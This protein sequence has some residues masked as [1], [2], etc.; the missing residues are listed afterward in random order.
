MHCLTAVAVLV[1]VESATMKESISINTFC[2]DMAGCYSEVL[3]VGR[4]KVKELFHVSIPE[5][6]D[7]QSTVQMEVYRSP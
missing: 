5:H 2:L 3:G 1:T 7:P 4:A 6:P